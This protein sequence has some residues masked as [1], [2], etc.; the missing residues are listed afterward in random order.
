VSGCRVCC[1]DAVWTLLVVLRCC[2]Q[3]MC[4][5]GAAVLLLTTLH[6]LEGNCH[7][8]NPV[9]HRYV[10]HPSSTFNFNIVI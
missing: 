3:G 2:R 10:L 9:R 4:A 5:C 6:Q 7:D 8:S 1:R